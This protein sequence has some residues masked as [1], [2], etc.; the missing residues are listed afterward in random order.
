MRVSIYQPVPG[1]EGDQVRGEPFENV[2]EEARVDERLYR[3]VFHGDLDVPDL[4]GV[5]TR[6]NEGPLPP[7][8]QGERLAVADIVRIE[9]DLPEYKRQILRETSRGPE[10]EY[11]SDMAKFEKACRELDGRHEPYRVEDVE[12]RHL[13]SARTGS[14]YCDTVGWRDL[15]FDFLRVRPM[16]G[17]RVLCL[18]VGKEPYET[19][20][21]TDL[22][23][24]QNAVSDHGEDAL[25]EFTYPFDDPGLILVGNEEAKLIGMEANRRIAGGVYA[26]PLFVAREG[27]D[28]EE[29][30]DLTDRDVEEL[31]HRFGKPEHL[32]KE[33]YQNELFFRFFGP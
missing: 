17:V 12:S 21:R 5:F 13:P 10:N 3:C 9:G 24:L 2:V 11:Y 31:T 25:I 29:F 23:S 1:P 22:R 19:R 7:M 6:L 8:Y 26:G 14:Y 30:S 27:P 15:D 16:E 4:E 32:T 33:D 28:G 20:I 18:P